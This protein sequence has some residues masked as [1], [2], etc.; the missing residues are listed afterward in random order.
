MK[1]LL[2]AAT[3]VTMA[4]SANA[5][6]S[7]PL[8]PNIAAQAQGQIQGQQQFTKQYQGNKQTASQS[9]ALEAQASQITTFSEER[10][11]V[12]AVGIPG[13]FSMNECM[14]SSAAGFANRI[15]SI[16]GS[17]T[18]KDDTCEKFKAAADLDRL[19]MK[20]DALFILCEAKIMTNAPSCVKLNA[21]VEAVE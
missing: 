15:I 14:G 10:R 3:L 17:T 21:A 9:A 7:N 12:N 16:G 4:M 13:S 8:Q 5:G 20:E 11:P 2:L 6:N 1:Q 19:G 18:W